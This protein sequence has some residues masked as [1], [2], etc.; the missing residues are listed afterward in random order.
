LQPKNKDVTAV[1]NNKFFIS[2]NLFLLNIL[3][4]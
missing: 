3:K 2:N 1:N 4:T